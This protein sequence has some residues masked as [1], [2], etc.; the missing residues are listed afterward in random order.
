[1]T[2]NDLSLDVGFWVLGPKRGEKT[3][4]LRKAYILQYPKETK[5]KKLKS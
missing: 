1:M 5:I 3:L 2:N 4:K